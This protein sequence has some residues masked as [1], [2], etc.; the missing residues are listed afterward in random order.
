MKD[1]IKAFSYLRTSG[2]GQVGNDGF[3]RQ[4]DT[5]SRYAKA[6]HMVIVQEF[7]DEAVSGTTDAMD[8]PGVTDLFVA[9]SIRF[10]LAG[11]LS[12]LATCGGQ[13][14]GDIHAIGARAG[15]VG[16]LRDEN[17]GLQRT[18]FSDSLGG[19]GSDVGC[20]CSACTGLTS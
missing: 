17:A 6:N 5:V 7:S 15:W 2:K 10:L 3:P 9:L 19:H 8:R 13:R 14:C 1:R 16:L 12:L 4:R 18:F 20:R 11:K